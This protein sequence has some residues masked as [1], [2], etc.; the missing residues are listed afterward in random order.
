MIVEVIIVN[1]RSGAVID[2]CLEALERQTT[3]HKVSIVDNASGDGSARNIHQKHPHASILPLRRNVGFARAV[4]IAAMRSQAE[5]VVTLNPDT[6]PDPH[7]IERVTAPFGADPAVGAVA[8][9]LVFE[10]RPDIIA[11]AGISMH[12]NGVAIDAMLGERHDPATPP[13][14]V[15]GPSAGAAA[16]RRDDFLKAGG[17]AE[18]F[19]MYLEDV[20]LAWRMRLLGIQ[21][22]WAPSAFVSH[23]YS[24]SAGEGSAFK[25][26]LLARNRIWTIARCLPDEL[27]WRDR[28]HILAFDAAAFGYSMATLDRAATSGRF[29]AM[30]GLLP[31]LAERRA[32]QRTRSATLDE[33]DRWIGPAMS[34]RRLRQLREMTAR[35]AS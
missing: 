33:I 11:S 18:P 21:S 2:A 10:S 6:V 23:R 4:N 16:Y 12:R 28:V 25:R 15:F 26:R 13:V 34:P 8:G 30:A 32:I 20:D 5:I 7:F 31:R 35:L 1:Y 19:F 27:W 22:V 9:T 29:S 3:P 24:S 14:P 17:L